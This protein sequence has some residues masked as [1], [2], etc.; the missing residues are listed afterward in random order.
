MHALGGR[1]LEPGH[2]GKKSKFPKPL[3]FP[4][5]LILSKRWQKGVRTFCE[6]FV[7][8]VFCQNPIFS[9]IVLL[10]IDTSQPGISEKKQKNLRSDAHQTS[11]PRVSASSLAP[12]TSSPGEEIFSLNSD[13]SPGLAAEL[14]RLSPGKSLARRDFFSL[15]GTRGR[16]STSTPGKIFELKIFPNLP[17]ELTARRLAATTVTPG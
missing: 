1:A 8:P 10:K 15:T 12:P 5:I 9:Y 16:L 3:A 7:H 4:G 14:S 13:F 11:S 2:G 6:Q 17:R